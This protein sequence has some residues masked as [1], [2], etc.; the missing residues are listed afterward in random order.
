MCNEEEER[1]K[2]E[3]NLIRS[4]SFS[5]GIVCLVESVRD[6]VK[7]EKF[8]KKCVFSRECGGPFGPRTPEPFSRHRNRYPQICLSIIAQ[9]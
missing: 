3:E 2:R 5:K 1:G 7:C 6:I 8:N 4:S 9:T